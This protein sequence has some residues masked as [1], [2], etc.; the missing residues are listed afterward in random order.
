MTANVEE[1]K[2]ISAELLRQRA[3]A[4]ANLTC[5]ASVL[6][7]WEDQVKAPM[8]RSLWWSR[9]R[10]MPLNAWGRWSQPFTATTSPK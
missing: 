8:T 9:P 4:C 7:R 5:R 3:C 6:F 1:A 2:R 10:L